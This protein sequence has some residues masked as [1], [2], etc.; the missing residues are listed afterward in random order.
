ME[1]A[2]ASPGIN[3]KYAA[4]TFA[5]DVTVN[6]KF[7]P[8]H[9]AANKIES[10]PYPRGLTNTQ[11]ALR[12][13]KRLFKD[14]SSV[15]KSQEISLKCD[16]MYREK[17]SNSGGHNNHTSFLVEKKNKVKWRTRAT[18]TLNKISYSISNQYL[19]HD[20]RSA[21]DYHVTCIFP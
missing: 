10:I 4:V 17:E 18:L 13:A 1:L 6:F 19:V 12:E 5:N 2:S 7:L 3:T 16:Q 8:Y 14:P 20:E 11:A 21:T 15:N 9:E